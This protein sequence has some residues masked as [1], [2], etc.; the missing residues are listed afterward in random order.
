VPVLARK[1]GALRNGAPFKDWVLPAAIERVRRKLVSADDGNR[2]MVDILNAVLTDGL[3]AVET[4]CAEA[5]AHGV[6]SADVVLNIL[7][8]Q[9]DPAPPANIATP[10]SLTLR[11]APIADCARYDNLRRTI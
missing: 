6:H 1:P 9:R 3:P 4:A 5:I 2:Q 10:A 11:H 7:A 8:R